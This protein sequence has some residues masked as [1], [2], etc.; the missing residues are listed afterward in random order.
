MYVVHCF[1]KILIIF[2]FFALYKNKIKFTGL[3]IIIQLVYKL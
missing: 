2:S 3:G 1:N